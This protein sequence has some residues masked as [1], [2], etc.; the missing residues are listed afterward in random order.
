[1]C[2]TLTKNQLRNLRKGLPYGSRRVIA[3]S[4]GLT[5]HQVYDTLQGKRKDSKVI[6]KALEIFAEEK[7]AEATI[8]KSLKSLAAALS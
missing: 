6:K 4:F 1:M 3:D 8:S 5:T 2:H 7:K